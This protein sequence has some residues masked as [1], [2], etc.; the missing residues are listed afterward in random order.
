[1]S[2]NRQTN[3][4]WS[5]IT[6]N[7]EKPP[8]MSK[9]NKKQLKRPETIKKSKNGQNFKKLS[10]YLEKCRKTVNNV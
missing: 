2:K 5:N 3:K 10:K 6:K 7:V 9:T 1:M 4:K 8:K